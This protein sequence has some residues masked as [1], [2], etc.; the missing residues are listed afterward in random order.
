MTQSNEYNRFNRLWNLITALIFF[1]YKNDEYQI[2]E[3]K[4]QLI[5]IKNC[6]FN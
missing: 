1:N 2:L 3:A 4:W 5:S 6:S